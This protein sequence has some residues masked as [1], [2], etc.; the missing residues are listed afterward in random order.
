MSYDPRMTLV[1][2]VAYHA[3]EPLCGSPGRTEWIESTRPESVTCPG[4]RARLAGVRR[5]LG[6]GAEGR[7]SS[8]GSDAQ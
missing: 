2:F 1:H 4:C 6:G 8:A 7:V 5:D 3:A